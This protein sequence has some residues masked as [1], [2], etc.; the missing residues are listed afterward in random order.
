[1]GSVYIDFGCGDRYPSRR[2][3]CSRCNP[4]RNDNC[5]I[6]PEELL[7]QIRLLAERLRLAET[8]IITLDNRVSELEA[9][10]PGEP[11]EIQEFFEDNVGSIVSVTTTFDPNIVGT[12][13]TA[14]TDAVEIASLD[15]DI[16]IIPYSSVITVS[17]E[18][19]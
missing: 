15:G 13:L 18:E 7:N 5:G 11:G 6:P 2:C 17:M 14:G 9:G 10:L 4:R 19:L 3:N 12:V 8:R 1:M 16:V